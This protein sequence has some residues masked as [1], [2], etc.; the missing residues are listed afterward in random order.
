[1][2]APFQL[3][4]ERASKLSGESFEGGAVLS[5][6]RLVLACADVKRFEQSDVPVVILTEQI[7]A[8]RGQG[9]H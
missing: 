4:V 1:M 5:S 7:V 2:G 9:P 8:R 6:A 3:P